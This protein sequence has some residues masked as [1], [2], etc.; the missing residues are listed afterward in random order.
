[1]DTIQGAAEALHFPSTFVAVIVLP[2]I[3]N[4]SEHYAAMMLAG[5][6]KLNL[7]L[8]IV[9]GA[10]TQIGLMVFPILVILG[11]FFHKDVSLLMDNGETVSYLCSVL[12][13]TL[14]LKDGKSNWISGVILMAAYG[15]VVICFWFDAPENIMTNEHK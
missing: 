6:N 9:L 15:V 2:I 4:C 11:M 14:V 13:A 12:L 8:G 7:T 5:K 3:V 10:G 1:M